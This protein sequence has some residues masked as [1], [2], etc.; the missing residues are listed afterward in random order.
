MADQPRHRS[1]F[2][3]LDSYTR[4]D[5]PVF[6]GRDAEIEEL[7]E[8]VF[9]SNL[10]LLYGASGTGKTSLI[11]CGLANQF[12]TTEWLPVSVRRADHLLDSLDQ[13]IRQQAVK[14]MDAS[15]TLAQKTRSLYLD[16]FKTVYLIFD[17][18]EE[19]FIFGGEEEQH[20]F[21]ESIAG[22]LA[23]G[24]QCKVILSLREEYLAFLSNFELVLP[25][26]FENRQRV[27]RMSRGNLQEVILQT[28]R[29]FDIELADGA[30]LANRIID[31]IKDPR[32]G[33]ELA[34][35]QIYLDK[36][37]RNDLERRG[38]VQRPIRFDPALL[39]STRQL[40]D[41]LSDFLEEQLALVEKELKDKGLQQEGIAMDV[42][43]ALVTEEGTKKNLPAA[44]LQDLVVNR[45]KVPPAIIAYCIRRFNE[46]RI[47][48]IMGEEP[49]KNVV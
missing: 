39:E 6:F 22:L 17:Q 19:L 33:V 46:L 36:L 4:E 8:R 14:P 1:P 16:Y 2:K 31:N 24:E 35:L 42:L 11:N 9:E 40:E 25:N 48:R 49:T 12:E 41:V 28:A 27:E 45:R 10:I 30:G 3:F 38:E 13:S 29:A 5:R 47:L 26:L 44:K 37:Y 43:F 18:F 15:W 32:Q 20:D 21:F 7:Y 34:N 23:A